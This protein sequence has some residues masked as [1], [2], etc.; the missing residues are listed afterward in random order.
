[1]SQTIIPDNNLPVY[2][3]EY[4]VEIKEEDDRLPFDSLK[5]A[6]VVNYSTVGAIPSNLPA[7]RVW[8][9]NTQGSFLPNV[10][11][12]FIVYDFSKVDYNNKN[13]ISF[14]DILSGTITICNHV[15]DASKYLRYR[16]DNLFLIITLDTSKLKF[17]IKK[18]VLFSFNIVIND[19]STKDLVFSSL[20]PSSAETVSDITWEYV[21][22]T[23]VL[24]LNSGLDESNVYELSITFSDYSGCNTLSSFVIK[25][26]QNIRTYKFG[27][28]SIQYNATDTAKTT[29]SF[30]MD[31]GDYFLVEIDNDTLTITPN[32][33]HLNFTNLLCDG[34]SNTE[35]LY[36]FFNWIYLG[37]DSGTG[38]GGYQLEINNNLN[39]VTLNLDIA[40]QNYNSCN[41][42]TFT[43][44]NASSYNIK[45]PE[46][47]I[48]YSDTDSDI[49]T[50]SNTGALALTYYTAT[51]TENSI[52]L[53]EV[54]TLHFNELCSSNNITAGQNYLV[55]TNNYTWEP[56]NGIYQFSIKD[57][58]KFLNPTTL[59]NL[60]IEFQNYCSDTISSFMIY[61]DNSLTLY[62]PNLT[63]QYS[64]DNSKKA[65]TTESISMDSGDYFLAKVDNDTLTITANTIDLNFTELCSTGETLF[66]F[67]WSYTNGN[68]QLEISDSPSDLTLSLNITFQNY[69]NTS[70]SNTSLSS[71]I[72]SNTSS[73]SIT[74][75]SLSIQYSSSDTYTDSNV[76]TMNANTTRTITITSS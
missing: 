68:Y 59:Q 72:I 73:Y 10:D 26:N 55:A 74:I 54:L 37:T 14:E 9:F 21:D 32:T 46:M 6:G 65:G 43:F 75:P 67:T 64:S 12:Y 24:L 5:K 71:F 38:S 60:D 16:Q 1:M 66:Y 29:N 42:S 50:I 62:I 52:S 40:F 76:I 20:C 34:S 22:Q 33:I 2:L 35:T 57:V 39:E 51:I 3:Q 19:D 63:I 25:N 23:Y 48:Q 30:S 13:G 8:E 36:P 56:I 47:S 41:L 11:T 45:I 15:L 17:K 31:P 18:E 69:S 70:C 28:L 53:V 58:V 49:A 61:N 4:V 27:S 44:Y 7:K